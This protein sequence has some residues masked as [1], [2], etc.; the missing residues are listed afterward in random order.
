MNAIFNHR[1]NEEIMSGAVS[2]SQTNWALGSI[3]GVINVF[4]KSVD[5]PIEHRFCT[6][7]VRSL[8]FSD[9]SKNLL[10]GDRNGNLFVADLETNEQIFSKKS[11]H[12]EAI[13]CV[14]FLSPDTFVVGDT[15]GN[16]KV[17][18]I[19]TGKHTH[20]YPQ[21][22]K[23]YVAD[24][25]AIDSMNFVVASGNGVASYFRTNKNK[26]V[27]YYM[28]EN[29]DFTSITYNSFQNHVV[30]SSSKPKIYVMKYPDF[31]FVCEAPGNNK[32]SPILM[33]KAI[34]TTPNRYVMVQEDGTVCI[35]EI[36]PNRPI[37]AFRAHKS[38]ARGAF[39]EGTTLL[40]WDSDHIAS[41]W[42]LT[43]LSQ[44]APAKKP[45][46]KKKS[47]RNRSIAV[48]NNDNFFNDF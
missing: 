13:E 35:T 47:K 17:W 28:Q 43:K 38:D 12:A 46:G 30:I 27:Q 23:D 11:A 3:S 22:E 40:T 10:A 4:T 14:K 48:K 19:R 41:V 6:G 37:D 31:D 42:D 8:Q 39:L 25:V 44:A 5:N 7:S 20:V 15:G 32:K 45:K 36:C 2:Q 24:I 18:D 21:V 34:K 9:D 16:V 33:V 29:D 1:L 26:R